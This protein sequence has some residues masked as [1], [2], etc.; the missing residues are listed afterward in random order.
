MTIGL[1]QFREP[2]WEH[3]D[4]MLVQP[5]LSDTWQYPFPQRGK[6]LDDSRE[7]TCWYKIS[8]TC[9]MRITHTASGRTGPSSSI[10]WYRCSLLA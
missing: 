3:L 1:M 8:R 5:F 4:R 6:P 10:N 9:R 7:E 2:S